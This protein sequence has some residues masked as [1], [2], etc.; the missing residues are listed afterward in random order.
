MVTLPKPLTIGVSTRALFRLE[1]EHSVFEAQGVE[2]YAQLQLSRERS[3]PEKGA[4]FEVVRRL[5][6]LNSPGSEKLVDVVLMSRNSPELSLRAFNAVNEYGLAIER[7]SFVSGRPVA[8]YATAWGI[9]LFLSNHAEDVHSAAANDVASATL[10]EPPS[11]Q[12][13]IAEDEVRIALDGDSVI[14]DPESDEIYKA[15]GL[16]AFLKHESDHGSVPLERGPFAR[17]LARLAI[18]RAKVMRS[19]G[20]SRVR[21]GLFTARNAPAH[22][23]V[24]RTFRDWH[25]PVDEAHFVG[26]ADK[27]P[28]LQA[29]GAHIFF[30]D[31]NKHVVS[32]Q[33]HVPAGWVPGPHSPETPVIPGR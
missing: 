33:R 26:S 32:A 10:L 5:L 9:D 20:S 11:S 23:R 8:P 18:V 25:T 29:F 27:G 13:A 14:F 22:E 4:A 3:V 28:F 30:D 31:Q 7:G 21:I 12:I 16:E 17:F 19:D 2:A 1:E 24:I 15:H 6:E